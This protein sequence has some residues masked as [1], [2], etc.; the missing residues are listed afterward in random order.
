MELGQLIRWQNL[1]RGTGVADP[2]SWHLL[3][4]VGNDWASG[5]GPDPLSLSQLLA[6]LMELM[7]DDS[8]EFISNILHLFLRI[9][10][11]VDDLP[12]LRIKEE[13][14]RLE[15]VCTTLA[16]PCLLIRYNSIQLEN[17]QMMSV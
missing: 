5:T 9:F 16:L 3:N 4:E 15:D 14:L 2:L 13:G 17:T 8:S 1:T 7:D 10:I 12:R 6:W 11:S